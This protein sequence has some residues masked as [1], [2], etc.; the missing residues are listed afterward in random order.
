MF[1]LIIF[2]LFST[3][4]KADNSKLPAFPGAE[5]FGY[6]SVG[7]RGGEVYHVTSHELTGPGTFHD[8]LMTAGDVPR[9]IVFD[10]SGEITIPKTV[11]N[12]KSNITIAGQTAP[13]DGI[14]IRGNTLRFI[15]SHDIIIRFVRFRMGA[16]TDFNDDAMYIEDSQ[17]VIIDHCTFSWATDEVLSIKSKN[18]EEPKSKNITVQWSIMSEGLLTHSMGGLIEMNTITMHHNVYAHNNDRNPKTKGQIDF[19]NNIVYN[20]GQ[21]PYV[22]GGES[23]TKGYGNVVGNYF[24]AG[25]NSK[26]P[27]YAIVRGN[28]N[29]Q[30]FLE[31]N[32]LDHNK[33][34]ILDG[35]DRETDMVEVERPSVIV[36]KRFAYPLVH[37]QEPEEAYEFILDH[38]GA[39][40]SRDD[41][42][43]RVIDSV[44]DQT[45]VIIGHE[46]DVGG[47]PKLQK[48]TPS[49]DSDGD[50]MPDEWENANGLDPHD[51]ADRNEDMHGEGY[52]NLEYYLNELAQAS[53]P[54]DYPTSPPEWAG[55]PFTPPTEPT[56]E[57]DPEESSSETLLG[58]DGEWLRN[59]LIKDNSK[60]GIDNAKKWSI[61]KNLQVGDFVAGDRLTGSSIYRF[62]TIPDELKGMEWIRSAV[63]SRSASNDDLVSFYLVADTDVYVAHDSRIGSIPGWLTSYEET[64]EFIEDDQPVSFKLYK[65]HYPAGSFV[66][67]GNN[68]NTK[69]MN[70]FIVLKPTK[71]DERPPTMA[72]TELE[73][74]ILDDAT[75]SLK[76]FSI[77]DS[78]TYLI[79]RST[80][81]E[82]LKAMATS[83]S[84]NF[85][86][87]SVE[88][89]YT[90]YYKVAA[91]N[92][93]GESPSSN[94]IELAVYDRSQPA[95]ATPKE[96]EILKAKSMSV[97]LSWEA[98]EDVTG[99]SIYRANGEQ[100]TYKKI[101][102]TVMAEY[103]DEQL[104]PDTKYYY[105][106]SATG[107]GGESKKSNSVS[108]KTGPPVVL[109]DIPSGL[110]AG[111]ISTTTF[112]IFWE[113]V[114]MAESY[115]IYR[116]ANEEKNF[117]LIA[118]TSS[119][120]YVDKSVSNNQSGYIYKISALNE[121][122]E[123]DH[124]KELVIAMPLPQVPIE[125][126]VGLVGET[127][128]GLIWTSGGG[129]N[130][131]NIYREANGK[132]ENVGYAKVETFYDRTVEPGVEY[133]YY[134]K[135]E[136]ARGESEAS[137]KV[138]ITPKQVNTASMRAFVEQFKETGEWNDEKSTHALT[139]HLSAVEIY[140]KQNKKE[141]VVKHM[142]SFKQ[143]AKK[144]KDGQ[145]LPI[146]LY[147]ILKSYANAMISKWKAE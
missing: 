113:E 41:V 76:W 54:V 26:D 65:K 24:I 81:K 55:P 50:G 92:A 8:A 109:P 115:N 120:S 118:N 93:A 106:V 33:N 87:S 27:E 112:E 119:T 35:T 38:A 104:T 79:Y 59:V 20:W 91:L 66:V 72:P 103:T 75:A 95:P 97:E 132:V 86:D 83:K 28:E 63:N 70:Y 12:N 57:P 67:M 138:T 15:N 45:G 21:Y 9:T 60:N 2:P 107:V 80:S 14:T 100:G 62:T 131:F 16:Q 78:D 141:K 42:D 1:C 117:S 29:Y 30:V 49:I 25:L 147:N 64:G 143:L 56:P 37:T 146:H 85:V 52:T 116:K 32:R 144:H 40:L 114:G 13:G 122:G 68:N 10:I 99:Y 82:R 4:A 127:F 111:K 130:Q 74:E 110:T 108:A 17:N 53:F 90:Y 101:A 129:G 3:P 19:V 61:E 139:L 23:G 47:Y 34:G 125:L 105:K 77:N 43:K 11:V 36:P 102:H 96:L 84:A 134:L 71:S 128:V 126:K 39:S 135:A 123:T 18:Y 124:S 94:E 136:N 5:G 6:A 142:E 73:G 121:I 137:N 88:L 46:D 133:T 140:E 51:P 7:G 69:Q 48:G 22:A 44:R 58:M 89:G 31:N 145:V 98:V